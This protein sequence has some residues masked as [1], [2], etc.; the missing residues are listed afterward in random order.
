MVISLEKLEKITVRQNNYSW[1]WGFWSLHTARFDQPT[2]I[3]AQE[4]FGHGEVNNH[5]LNSKSYI[6][7]K[8]FRIWCE[9]NIYNAF[10]DLIS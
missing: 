6:S 5:K 4:R 1:L 9:T 7:S 10:L 3:L 8:N 2:I